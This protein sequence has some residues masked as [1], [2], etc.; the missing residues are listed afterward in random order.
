MKSLIKNSHANWESVWL[1]WIV[2]KTSGSYNGTVILSNYLEFKPITGTSYLIRAVWILLKCVFS[3]STSCYYFVLNG[4]VGGV[5]WYIYI[6]H[7]RDPTEVCLHKILRCIN[8]DVNINYRCKSEGVF[9]STL[10]FCQNIQKHII[11]V[12]DKM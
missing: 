4:T 7:S 12:S 5:S 6:K 1:F 3:W 2:S 8:T 9:S 10:V 11:N